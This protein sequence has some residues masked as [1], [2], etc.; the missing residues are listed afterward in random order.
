MHAHDRH[1]RLRARINRRGALAH[2]SEI[3]LELG[4]ASRARELLKRVVAHHTGINAARRSR[5]RH[6][7][8]RAKGG[9][10]RGTC[11]QLARTRLRPRLDPRVARAGDQGTTCPH[12][13]LKEAS[14]RAPGALAR[15]RSPRERIVRIAAHDLAKGRDSL[16]ERVV[17]D[18]HEGAVIELVVARILEAPDGSAASERRAI[19]AP[20]RDDDAED[21]TLRR[22][23]AALAS[24]QRARTTRQD[25]PRAIGI[26]PS[27]SLRQ[28]L[29]LESD[30]P[31]LEQVAVPKRI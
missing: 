14:A 26:V 13:L 3:K 20:D 17:A 28:A 2:A 11:Q 1:R 31:L 4:S 6:E 30:A 12:L 10:A 29:D 19:E 18:A 23:G 27:S 8:V 5:R 16:V 25:S 7:R 22:F 21:A 9:A 24:A 15:S